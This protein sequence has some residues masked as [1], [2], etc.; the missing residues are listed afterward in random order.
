LGISLIVAVASLYVLSRCLSFAWRHFY[1]NDD[2]ER[3][4]KESKRLESAISFIFSIILLQCKTIL[5]YYL[6]EQLYTRIFIQLVQQ[7]K[8]LVI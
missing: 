2:D 4:E 3:T 1:D 6:Q 8:E 7:K 5:I